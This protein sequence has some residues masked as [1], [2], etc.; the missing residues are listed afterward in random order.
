MR[1]GSILIVCERGG[2]YLAVGLKIV[3]FFKKG[4]TLNNKHTSNQPRPSTQSTPV[5]A[6]IVLRYAFWL[7]IILVLPG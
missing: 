5:T 1:Y 4:N 3:M 2:W 6:P 7:R